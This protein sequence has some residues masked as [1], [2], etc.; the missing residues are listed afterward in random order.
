MTLSRNR[1]QGACQSGCNQPHNIVV[2]IE[3]EMEES[4]DR[5]EAGARGQISLGGSGRGERRFTGDTMRKARP[6][7][8]RTGYL[9]AI[10]SFLFSRK[11]QK[12]TMP[13]FKRGK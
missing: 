10:S 8:G 5:L 12:R 2:E 4:E 1:S 3:L 9:P 11:Y 6:F 13:S 7:R